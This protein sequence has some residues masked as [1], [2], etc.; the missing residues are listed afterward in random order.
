M[1]PAVCNTEARPLLAY[2]P[3]NSNRAA[4]ESQYILPRRLRASVV[5]VI[6]TGLLRVRVRPRLCEV[7]ASQGICPVT[8]GQDGHQRRQVYEGEL[9]ASHPI[10]DL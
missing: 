2:S 3:F 1:L 7:L 6:A 9:E 8:R 10:D 5:T 4:R